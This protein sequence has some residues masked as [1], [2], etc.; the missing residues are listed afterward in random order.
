MD[1]LSIVSQLTQDTGIAWY[2]F[3]NKGEIELILIGVGFLPQ[4]LLLSILISIASGLDARYMISQL[5][6]ENV[7]VLSLTTIATPHRG[8]AFA[9]HVFERIGRKNCQHKCINDAC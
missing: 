9:D 2:D 4:I 6:P 8:S 3:F 7:K 5:K 1:P